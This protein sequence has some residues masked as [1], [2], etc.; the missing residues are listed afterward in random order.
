MVLPTAS[1]DRLRKPHF[2]YT[3][4]AGHKLAL[5]PTDAVRIVSSN[6]NGGLVNNHQA[7]I[8]KPIFSVIH[9]LVDHMKLKSDLFIDLL[10]TQETGG[11]KDMGQTI[12]QKLLRGYGRL[13]HAP[14]NS[15]HKAGLAVIVD[16]QIESRV[17]GSTHNSTGTIQVIQMGTKN[18]RGKKKDRFITIINVY[19]PSS[20]TTSAERWIDYLDWLDALANT[21]DEHTFAGNRIIIMG[22]WNIAP[23][24][25]IDR[26]PIDNPSDSTNRAREKEKELWLRIQAR[27]NM[28]DIFRHFHPNTI[29]FSRIG[30][31]RDSA[32]EKSKSRIDL[33][34][35]RA[36]D[37]DMIKSIAYYTTQ[38][39]AFTD[40]LPLL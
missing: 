25:K 11:T 12:T 17:F 34:L 9:K 39:I 23:D 4:F 28:V 20:P 10:L 38:K 6:A 27:L 1:A 35:C 29:A 19:A 5:K 14:S 3:K 36:V 24:W 30:D 21:V 2:E 26:S 13:L 33:A 15:A 37:V 16:K 8:G 22:D 18:K 7:L 31:S 32:G 40:H